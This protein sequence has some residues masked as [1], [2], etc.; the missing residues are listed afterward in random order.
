MRMPN[1][2]RIISFVF[3]GHFFPGAAVSKLSTTLSSFPQHF[4]RFD[5]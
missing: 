1:P 2:L 4:H 5:G 3:N